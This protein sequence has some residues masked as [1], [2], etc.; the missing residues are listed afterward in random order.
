MKTAL[1]RSR[2]DDTGDNK[3]TL[4]FLWHSLALLG[5]AEASGVLL[6]NLQSSDPA[7]RTYA[8]VFAGESGIEAAAPVLIGQLDDENLDARIRAAQAL[9][10][11]A[12]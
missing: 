4:A 6:K 8:A 5:D 2:L 1:V 10:V 12:R 9:L 7:V 3:L 11:L